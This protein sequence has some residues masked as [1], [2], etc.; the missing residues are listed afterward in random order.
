MVLYV[1]C[2]RRGINYNRSNTICNILLYSWKISREKKIVQADP[3]RETPAKRLYDGVDYVPANKYVLYGH[4]FASIAGAGP[5]VGPAIALGW[6]WLPSILWVWFGNVFVGVV[7]DYLA[8]MS[9]VRYDGRTIGWIAGRLMG[10]KATY[11]FNAYIWF[12]LLL[13]VAAFGYVISVL[14]A[15]VPG[16]GVSALLL[17]FFAVIIGFL[18]YKT[19]LSFTGATVIAWILIILA[20][21]L[22]VISQLNNWIALDMYSWLIIL[23]IYIIIAASLPVWVLLQPR[24]YMNAYILWVSLAI[25]GGALIWLLV[26]GQGL[27]EFPAYTSFSATVVGGQPS[28]FWPTV[29]LVIACGALSGFHSLVGSGTSS[30]Q[31]A[32][33]L[34]GLL[35]AYGGMET[36]GFLST[37]VIGS[38]SAFGGAAFVDGII[39][40]WSKVSSMVN[41]IATHLGMSPISEPTRQNLQ[42]LVNNFI[43]NPSVFGKF[44]AGLANA[45]KWSVIPRSYAYA[46]NAAFGLDLTVMTIFGTLWIT[47]FA[48]TSLDTATRLG[49]YAWQELME[50]LKEG[51]RSLYKVLA[52]KWVASAIIALLGILLAWGGSFLLLWPAFAGMN[53][54]LSSLALMTVSVWVAKIQ[55]SSI[56][57]KALVVAPAI[58]MWITVTTALLWFEAAVIPSWVSQGGVKA[59]TGITVGIITA[60][61]VALNIYLFILW[62]KTMKKKTI[63][64]G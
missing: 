41:K 32:N 44:Y 1:W 19:K 9:S 53:Q 6:G 14:F 39:G 34:H 18:M 50:P 38:M 31:L 45:V 33:E 58:F 61:G 12:S 17:L 37:M 25:G 48:L 27:L 60:I 47:G 43:H 10:R 28:P 51:A 21:Y 52:N 8:L 64:E 56:T 15:G 54:L 22:G 11:V 16:A 24:D 20:I 42:L 59:T 49:R 62:L 7:H 3:N 4:H 40:S 57:G 23:L 2:N 29:P 5:I 35:V 55:K 30:K 26:K 36:E 63:E 46:T 13:V